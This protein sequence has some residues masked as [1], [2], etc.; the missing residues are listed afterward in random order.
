[1]ETQMNDLLKQD[2]QRMQNDLHDVKGKVDKMYHAL[3]G[4]ELLEDGG[5]IGRIKALEVK[6]KQ[7]EKD[8]EEEK[9]KNIKLDIYQ[10]LLWG[11]AGVTATGIIGYIIQVIFTQHK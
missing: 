7:F 10:K 2:M 4:N 9:N 11:A 6:Q 8:L 1:M 5:I 3:M